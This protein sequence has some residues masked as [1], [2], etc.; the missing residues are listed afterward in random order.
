MQ[1]IPIDNVMVYWIAFKEILKINRISRI[2]RGELRG[3]C[4]ICKHHLSILPLYSLLNRLIIWNWPKLYTNVV[5]F[6]SCDTNIE[7]IVDFF[8][9]IFN[10]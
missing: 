4:G 8:N 6:S 7:I 2:T 5:L 10:F 3:N 1:S 9:L